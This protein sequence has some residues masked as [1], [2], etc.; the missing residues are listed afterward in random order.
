MTARRWKSDAQANAEALARRESPYANAG[1][2]AAPMGFPGALRW[3]LR[4]WEGELKGRMHAQGVEWEAPGRIERGDGTGVTDPGGG[5]AL[6]SPRW[7]ASTRAHLFGSPS[8]TDAD[9]SYSEPLH[10][11]VVYVERRH[12]LKARL[13]RRVGMGADWRESVT[14]PACSTPLPDEYG[15]AVMRDAV[16]VAIKHYR[17]A[18]NSA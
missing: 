14:C 13:L 12:P 9:G 4:T 1:K 11:A 3:F 17:E 10:F 5:N 2:Y 8:R 6:G 7:D 15:E 18:P 16:T